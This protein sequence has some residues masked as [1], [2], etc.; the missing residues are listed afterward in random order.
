MFIGR[1]ACFKEEPGLSN[2]NAIQFFLLDA[3]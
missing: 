3:L 2:L 1:A